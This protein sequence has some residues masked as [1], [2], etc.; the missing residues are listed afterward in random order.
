[1]EMRKPSIRQI[2]VLYSVVVIL[3]LFIG[4]RVQHSSFYIGVLITE[5]LLIMLPPLVML[6]I[7]KFDIKRVLRLNKVSF[8]SIFIIFWI[9]I[10]ALPVVGIINLA[11]LML[12]KHIFG[13]VIVAQ[14]PV[15]TNG[16][17]LLLNVLVIG[18]SAGICEEVL[19]RGVIQRGFERFGTVKA[20]LLTSFLFGLLHVDF[21]KLLGTFLLGALI[22]F[23][24]YRTNSLFSG[25]FAHFTNNSL[26]VVIA[27]GSNKL[28]ELLNSSG[29]R[30][31]EESIDPD[32][33][34]SMLADMPQA[35]LIGLIV[36]WTF[37]ILF[38]ASILTGLIIG[39][40]KIT[41]GKPEEIKQESVNSAIIKLLWFLPGVVF[42]AFIYFAEG[43]K[44][45]GITLGVV[46]SVLRFIGL[47]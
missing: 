27:Y 29:M 19:F 16:L 40:V 10:F 46:E 3:F 37:I 30:G 13:R 35:Q 4:S 23:I 8:L 18:A 45:R 42:I 36:G 47:G 33:Y 38:C 14:P 22:G 6:F 31:M 21:Q 7:Y 39:L 43:L 25:M 17:E 26:A 1:M 5:F 2:G 12:I 15:A 11:N 24:V 32:K 44:L 34:F 20:I 41:E 9:M 28:M